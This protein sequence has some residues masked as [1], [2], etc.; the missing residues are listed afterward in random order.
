MVV[1][2]YQRRRS[3]LCT[4]GKEGDH[5]QV[6]KKEKGK[7]PQVEDRGKRIQSSE[8]WNSRAGSENSDLSYCNWCEMM[9]NL[10]FILETF[11][12]LRKEV[13]WFDLDVGCFG[14]EKGRR[15][16]MR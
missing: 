12:L 16:L 3:D 7:E 10:D 1:L 11:S 14:R 4:R 13:T 5:N 15:F 9:T 6:E 8:V 2:K